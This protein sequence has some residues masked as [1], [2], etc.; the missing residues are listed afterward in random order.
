MKKIEIVKEVKF[1]DA[2][3]SALNKATV[4]GVIKLDE[5]YTDD[6]QKLL[7]M[8]KDKAFL[9]YDDINQELPEGLV[10]PDDIEDI[11]ATL[12]GEGIAISDSEEKFLETAAAAANV[13]KKFEETPEEEMELDLSPGA[14]DKTNDPVRLYLREMGVVPLLTR[15]GEVAIAKRIERGKIK[16]QKAI[17][18]SPIAIAE[19]LKIGEE[20]QAEEFSIR[21]VV[22][23]NEQEGITE[24]KIE[25][26]HNY[27]L[28]TIAETGKTFKKTNALYEKFLAEPK[29][30]PKQPKLRRKL[31]RQRIELSQLVR[32]LEFTPKIQDRLVY[33]MK[34]AKAEV[35]ATEKDVE[36]LSRSLER[37]RNADEIR[38][39][40][41]KLRAAKRHLSQLEEQH[42]QP[43]VEIKRA[44]LNV[45][46][47]DAHAQQAKKELVE[48]NLRL[49]VSIAK[50][51]TNRGLQFLDLIQEGNIGLMKAV[52]KFEY[53]R[54]YK[55]ST[56]ATWWIRQAITRAIADQARTIR[57]PVHMI[58]TINKLIRTSR[59]L[60]Q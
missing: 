50:K 52:D 31:A 16:T 51:Y 24:E 27:T 46:L 15:E 14:L 35:S 22:T 23:F 21:E 19:L 5:K 9:T 54:G 7:D 49:V 36:K 12:S 59:A 20:L 39:T 45:M 41:K 57:I 17:S 10:S 1:S 18:R 26:Y 32:L 56:Y 37:K 43:V 6:V 28:E 42:K 2:V 8:G 60:V 13:D 40:E 55:F 11:F 48:A 29:R 38:E 4:K 53:R 33:T 58:E 3:A 47:G 30:S 44:V 34:Q 25:E